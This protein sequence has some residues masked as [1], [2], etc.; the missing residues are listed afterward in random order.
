M[1][2]WPYAGKGGRASESPLRREKNMTEAAEAAGPTIA[3]RL[4]R[5]P[6]NRYVCKLVTLISFGWWFE[7]YDL[8]FTAYIGVG[9]FKSGLSRPRYRADRPS[10][11][12]IELPSVLERRPR[13]PDWN[14][15]D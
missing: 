12:Y 11:N 15:R 9:L 13:P 7:F 3:A 2:F 5:L 1:P 8:F 14:H 10:R 6:P 4:D